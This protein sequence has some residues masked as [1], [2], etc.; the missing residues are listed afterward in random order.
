MKGFYVSEK[1]SVLNASNQYVFKVFDD[2]TKNEVKKQVEKSFGVKVKGVKM[3]NLPKKKRSVGRHSGFKAG[4]KKAVVVLREG[5]AID[6]AK[7]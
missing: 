5:Y 7:A 1:A 6:Q 2:T 3:I 4:I